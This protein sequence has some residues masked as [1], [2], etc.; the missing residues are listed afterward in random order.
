MIF[1]LTVA[2]LSLWLA[3]VTLILLVT[4]EVIFALPDAASI[5]MDKRLLRGCAVGCGL[6]FLVTVALKVINL[7]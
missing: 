1:P 3:V 5:F 4:S 2:D 6:A 7:P